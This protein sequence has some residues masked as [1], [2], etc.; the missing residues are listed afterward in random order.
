[1]SL[2]ERLMRL[3]GTALMSMGTSPSA[4]T[5]SVC[6]ATP[7][8]DGVPEDG[9]VVGLCGA[10]REDDLLGLRAEAAG[11]GGAGVFERR[12]RVV[13]D[14]VQRRRVAEGAAEV[15]QHRLDHARVDGLG[16]LVV[17]V[18]DVAHQNHIVAPA[19]SAR[20]F[21]VAAPTILT[22]SMSSTV[23]QPS[24]CLEASHTYTVMPMSRVF[25]SISATLGKLPS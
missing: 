12:R 2:A 19:S 14:G 3:T 18:D 1:M 5:A 13:A 4:A 24:I 8:P 11:D 25:L 9:E 21:K 16:G 22:P 20:S 17:G 10:R 6:S 7:E 23:S 15:R